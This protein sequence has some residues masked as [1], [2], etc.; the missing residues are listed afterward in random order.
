[1]KIKTA[2]EMRTM[3][4]KCKLGKTFVFSLAGYDSRVPPLLLDRAKTSQKCFATFSQMVVNISSG[5]IKTQFGMVFKANQL[6]P[7]ETIDLLVL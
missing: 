4:W 3:E 5:M 7:Q 2:M 6:S 1:M